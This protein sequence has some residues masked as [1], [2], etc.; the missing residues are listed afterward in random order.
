MLT[1]FVKGSQSGWCK[2]FTISWKAGALNDFFMCFP[3]HCFHFCCSLFA[4]VQPDMQTLVDR[5]IYPFLMMVAMLLAVLSFQIRQFKRL[6]EH[7]KNDK[8]VDI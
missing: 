5:R 3:F 4:G 2:T 1:K 8:L 7:I 6:Y